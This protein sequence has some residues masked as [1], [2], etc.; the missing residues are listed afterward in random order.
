MPMSDPLSDLAFIVTQ[1]SVSTEDMYDRAAPKYEH[2]RE[3][4]LKFAGE[5]AETAMLDAIRKA[6]RPGWKILDAGAGTGNLARRIL[7][8]EPAASV[9]MLDISENMLRFASEISGGRVRGSVLDLPFRDGA[10]D[11]VVSGWV[12]ETVPDPRQAVREFLRV[13][14]PQGYVLYTFC[15]LPDGWLSR[16]GSSFLRKAVKLGFAGDFLDRTQEP[17]HDC[18]KS[19]M[20]R[21]RRGVSTFVL[22]RKCCN[23]DVGVLPCEPGVAG[24]G[25]TDS[26]S[27]ERGSQA[28]SS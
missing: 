4:W 14:S 21:S 3:L 15:S 24:T 17:W 23:V 6:I 13:I 10:F 28:R 19:H 9:T 22:L 16:A 7:E 5:P 1:G 11:L 2:F 20:V 8:I 12:I 26:Q 27:T 18:G 25:N